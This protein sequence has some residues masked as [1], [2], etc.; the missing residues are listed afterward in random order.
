MS[1]SFD[2][3]GMHQ[4][5]VKYGTRYSYSFLQYGTKG[6]TGGNLHAKSA[7]LGGDIP[8]R[9]ISLN[10]EGLVSRVDK[11][12][13]VNNKGVWLV[14]ARLMPRYR[15]TDWAA[16]FGGASINV[17]LNQDVLDFSSL[18]AKQ[19]PWIGYLVG[20]ELLI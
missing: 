10:I 15:I 16:V 2:D 6:E 14:Q 19:N 18:Y 17:K 9:R 1:Y 7:G 12:S 5:A 4:F 13:F 3:L 8:F 11:N 20:F